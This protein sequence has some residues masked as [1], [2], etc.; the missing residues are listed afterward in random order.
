MNDLQNFDTNSINRKLE[1]RGTG[2]TYFG[3]WIVNALLTAITLGIYYAWAKTKERHFL[4]SNTYLADSTFTYHG[5]GKELFIG[6]VKAF[7]VFAVPYLFLT[8]ASLMQ[9]QTLTIIISILFVAFIIFII[10]LAVHGTLRFRTARTSWRGI[11]MGYSGDRNEFVK[12]F[13]KNILFT[14]L[15]LGFY[16]SWANVNIRKYIIEHLNFGNIKAKF[17][18]NGGD[19][20]GIHIL[21]IF[22]TIFTLGIYSFWY[23]KNVINFYITNTELEQDGNKIELTSSISGGGVFGLT[24]VNFLLIIFTIGLAIPWVVIRTITFYLGNVQIGNNFNPEKIEQGVIDINANAIGDSLLDD[25][26]F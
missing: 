12:L 7:F 9:E 21:G 5:T 11:F 13:F 26:G 16:G 25:I 23:T 6:Y 24:V 17:N 2:G 4:Y 8:G 20:F 3:I 18:G 10:P 1:F 14:I 19:L 22:L 15:T